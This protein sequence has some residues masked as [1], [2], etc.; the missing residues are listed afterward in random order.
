ML[1]LS[2]FICI[3]YRL[4]AIKSVERLLDINDNYTVCLALKRANSLKMK[5]PNKVQT[6]MW[7]SRISL[8][9]GFWILDLIYARFL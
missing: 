5:L 4:V 1:Y 3:Y 7:L 8:D 6:Q 9:F 2:H